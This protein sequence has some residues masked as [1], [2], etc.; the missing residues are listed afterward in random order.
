MIFNWFNASEA[1]EFGITLAELLIAR[2]P[3]DDA[4]AKRMVTKKH[5]A[6]LHQLS[7]RVIQFKLEHKLNIYKKAKLGNAFKW[8]LRDKGYDIDYVDQMTNWLMLKL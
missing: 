4:I 8:A 3:I 7:Q 6:M 1:K 5:E 2:T